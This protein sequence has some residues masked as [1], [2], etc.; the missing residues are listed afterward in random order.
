MLIS[1]TDTSMLRLLQLSSVSLPVGGY[2]F[3]QGLEYAID[4]NWVSD[5]AQIQQWLQMQLSQSI[6]QLELPILRLCMQTLLEG[7]PS[8]L[9]QYNDLALASRESKELRLTDTAMGEALARVLRKQG[10]ELHFKPAEQISFV[11]MFAVAAQHW[12]ISYATAALGFCW[13]WLENQVSAATKLVPLGQTQAQRLLGTLQPAIL[14]AINS[15][16]D[17]PADEVGACLPALAIASALHEPQYSR[18]FRS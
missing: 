11:V 4:S 9:Q 6:A 14:E 7:K 16:E 5:E 15:A 10:I 17:I 12:E 1:S 18:L 3:S 2:A 13:S 8:G